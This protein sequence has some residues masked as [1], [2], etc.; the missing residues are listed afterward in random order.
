MVR[1]GFLECGVD[2]V[3]VFFD[4]DVVVIGI[5]VLCVIYGCV[6]MGRV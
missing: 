4:V 1:D 5:V 3:E 6:V 2:G